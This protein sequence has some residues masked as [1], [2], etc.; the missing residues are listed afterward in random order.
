[1]SPAEAYAVIVGTARPIAGPYYRSGRLG[2]GLLDVLRARSRV[3]PGYRFAHLVLPT[4]VLA[5]L[6]VASGYLCARHGLPG[7]FLSV[8]AWVIALPGACVAVVQLGRW[9]EFV[10]GGSLV[11]GLGAGTALCAGFALALVVHQWQVLKTLLSAAVPA[12]GLTLAAGAGAAGAVGPIY[13]ACGA[14]AAT[15]ALAGAWEVRTRRLLA[16]LA[17]QEPPEQWEAA[18]ALIRLHRHAMDRRIRRRTLRMLAQVHDERVAE[19]LLHNARDGDDAAKALAAMGAADFALLRPLVAGYRALELSRRERLVA[20][21]RQVEMTDVGCILRR[22]AEEEDSEGARMLLED[23][24]EGEEPPP[25]PS[26][27]EPP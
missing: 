5:L 3:S 9:L 10:G 16:R 14:A 24:A 19:F 27:P 12:V 2:A 26:W 11:V 8:L 25:L 6:A 13:L 7:A 17:E 15:C 21:L 4:A 22:M 23:L 20:A 1:M 18:E